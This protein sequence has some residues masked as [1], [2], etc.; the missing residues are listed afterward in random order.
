[1]NSSL[2]RNLA[3]LV[4]RIGLGYVFLA[5]G[6]QKLHDQGLAGT[7]AGFQKM[8]V[9]APEASAYFATFVELIGGAALILGLF[10]GLVGLLLVGD[11]L[12]AFFTVHIGNGV[13]VGQGGY[14]LVAALGAGALL[15]AVLGAGK[16]AVDGAIV[17]KSS[18]IAGLA[19][20]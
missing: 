13:F 16:F 4:A 15:L 19:R 6:W 11:M 14:E 9:P 3:L 1:M 7:A 17:K 8:G 10:T 20:A 18:W 2:L 12:G 5:H